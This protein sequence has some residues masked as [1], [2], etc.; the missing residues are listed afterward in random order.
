MTFPAER[1][2]C[3][4]TRAADAHEQLLYFT[5]SSLWADDRQLVFLSD[6]DGHP[7]IYRLDRESG[8]VT[9]L[10][11]NTEGFLKSYV[12]FDG[13]PY[14]GLGKASVSLDPASGMV[15]YLQGRQ[16][17]QAD[18]DGNVRV[19]AELPHGQMTA[20]S[21]VSVDGS[22]LCLPTTDARALD[23]DRA[24]PGRPDYD[25][26]RRVREENLSSY[27]WIFDTR[28]GAVLAR[29]PVPRAWVTHVQFSP[30]D[31]DLILYNHEWPSDCGVRRMWLFDGTRHIPL[32]PEGE[33]R[34]RADWTCHE[35]WECDGQ[36]VIYH[37][38]Y[39]NGP[40]YLG[41]ARLDGASVVDLR[42]ITLPPGWDAYGHFTAG[43]PGTLVT[44][45]YYRQDGAPPA[46]SGIW[47]SW[48]DVDWER[49]ETAWT[50]L[51]RH[52]SSWDSQDSHPHPIFDHAAQRV[53]FTS[54]VDGKRAVY[55]V[56]AGR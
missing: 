4:E 44:D 34:S 41:R 46:R 15:Y 33:G 23:G 37:G 24:L 10:S 40:A 5:S 19:L 36:A 38:Q 18:P 11:R 30:V 20:F 8:A 48:V 31:P 7:N 29:E 43:A 32:R 50:P 55:S 13:A 39:H 17:C 49:G 53:Y 45:G 26:D 14:R 22:R 27:L 52:G 16:V 42:E 12:Y 6:R 47:I 1:S 35:M 56:D 25:I 3:R 9:K 21:H 28:T 2:V 54:D 51:C